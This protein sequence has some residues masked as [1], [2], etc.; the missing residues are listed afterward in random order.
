MQELE[1]KFKHIMDI[2]SKCIQNA[3]DFCEGYKDFLNKSKTE[4][5][6]ASFIIEEAKK[7]GYKE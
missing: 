3:N 5:E 6:A 7:N 4:R 1:F 2:D